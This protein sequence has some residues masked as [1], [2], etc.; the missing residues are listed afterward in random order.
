MRRLVTLILAAA[1]VLA[2]C[3]AGAQSKDE[4]VITVLAAASL[5]E[6]FSQVG[7]RFETAHPGTKVRL[8]F[9]GSQALV[10]QVRQ[11]VPADVLATADEES[12]AKAAEAVEGDPQIFARNRLVMVTAPGNPKRLQ[13]LRD[14]ARR[15]VVTVLAAETVPAG[16][17]ARAALDAEGVR[18][19][20]RSFEDD[21]RA[22]LTRVRLG[23]ADAGVV[24]VTDAQSAGDKVATVQ[25]PQPRGVAIRYPIAALANAPQPGA[26]KEFLAYV[27][28]AEGQAA[29]AEAGFEAP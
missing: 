13:G 27:L 7:Q 12:M 11:G 20:P 6:A 2:G 22:V 21:V 23:E 25:I 24:Y 4:R 19:K 9:A 28:S 16:R 5:S 3:S 18:V 29:L 15:D 1:A 17:Y 10:A 26:A 8:S 14:L